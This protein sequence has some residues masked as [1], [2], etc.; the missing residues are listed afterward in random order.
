MD[1]LINLQRKTKA[2]EGSIEYYWFEN[3]N[4]GLE[5][6]LFHRISI[7]LE[8]FDSEL[9]YVEQPEETEI[10]FEWYK[11]NLDDPNKLDGLDLSQDN[12]PEAESS[13]YIGAAHNWCKIISLV[14]TRL[15]DLEF[16]IHGELEIDFESEGVGRNESFQFDT[17]VLLKVS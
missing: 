6:T 12:Y 2:K 11:L 5:R 14:L 15:S 16:S 9:S 3:S 10:V 4:V 13:V 1:N 7:P 8:P 17:K